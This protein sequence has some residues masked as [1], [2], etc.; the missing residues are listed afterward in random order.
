MALIRLL[1][2]CE[3]CQCYGAAECLGLMS[4]SCPCQI[5]MTTSLP[6][7]T[8]DYPIAPWSLQGTALMSFHMVDITAM[9]HFLPAM[10]EILPIF[11]G[12]TLGGIYLSSYGKGSVLSY[13]E[14]IVFCGLVRYGDRISTWVMHIYVDH[15]QSVAGGRNIWGLPK[16]LASFRWGQGD[17][18]QVT[19]FQEGGQLCHFSYRWRLPGIPT[20]IPAF[21]GAFSW[22]QSQ[23]MWF[24][25]QG[26]VKTHW[27]MEAAIEVPDTSPFASLNFTHPIMAFGLEDLTLC[28]QPPTQS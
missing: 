4:I 3:K 10:L 16:Q 20:P 11:P 28:V 5:A 13:N 14:L 2:V 15:P 1:L 22:L 21:A 25:V 17:Q 12:K 23:V 7:E 6:T 9:Q 18:P 8:F 24:S 26:S 19:V 27:L